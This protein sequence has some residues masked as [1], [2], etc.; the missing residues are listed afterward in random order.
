MT[1]S[2]HSFHLPYH[3]YK[4]YDVTFFDDT[5]KT[6][7]THTP[8]IV[9]TWISDIEH[10]NRRRLRDLVVGLDVEWRPNSNTNPA[11]TLQ[12]CVGLN[13]L[14]F[15]LIFAPRMPKSLVNFLADEDYTFVGIGIEKD[16]HKLRED[17]GLKV[18]NW[19]DLRWLAARELR[20]RQLRNVGLVKLAREVLGKEFVKPRHVTLSDWDDVWLSRE[21]IQYACVDA[22]VSFEIGRCL[23]ADDV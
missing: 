5:I 19:V 14:I 21:Q 6:L 18:R 23:D 17:Y 4:L 2:I 20:D 22:F 16:V 9:G 8:C 12:L 3:S 15:H 11:A 13:C 10:L 1:I 7:V